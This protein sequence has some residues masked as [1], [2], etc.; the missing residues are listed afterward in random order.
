[1]RILLI[2]LLLASCAHGHPI[3]TSSTSKFSRSIE[4]TEDF[5]TLKEW[6]AVIK[7]QKIER[8]KSKPT[9]DK[10]RMVNEECNKKAY[11]F[12]AKWY[13]PNEMNNTADCKGFSICKYYALRKAGMTPAQ[14][15]IWSG[16]YDGNPHMMLVASLDNKEYALDIGSESG[17]PLAKDYFYKHF[18]PAYRFNETGWD[19]N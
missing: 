13:T 14:L 9:L 12:D 15:N 8:S 18:K 4:T 5:K 3:T 1:M 2:A 11:K 16:D 17:L 6:N 19:V 7:R 10:I